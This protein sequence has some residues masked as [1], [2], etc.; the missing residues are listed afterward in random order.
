M[1]EGV[2]RRLAYVGADGYTVAA[3]AV[4]GTTETTIAGTCLRG[5]QPGETIRAIGRDM[6][7]S[8]YAG[9]IRVSDCERVLPATVHAMRCYLGSGLIRGIG[10]ELADAI[11]GQ[12]DEDT[13][14][15][16]DTT[17]RLLD[18][19]LVGPI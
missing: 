2:V 18:V 6:T 9:T 7:G 12:F 3:I 16:I 11:V 4:D 17:R 19:H 13:L 8:R 14:T 5:L 10:A 15:V 1:A